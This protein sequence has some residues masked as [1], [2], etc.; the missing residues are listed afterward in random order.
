MPSHLFTCKKR[1]IS[2]YYIPVDVRSQISPGADHISLS[3][4]RHRWYSPSWGLSYHQGVRVC[5]TRRHFYRC[6]TQRWAACQ[7]C[8]GDVSARKSSY[9]QSFGEIISGMGIQS[10]LIFICGNDSIK[11]LN[12]IAAHYKKNI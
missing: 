1:S 3:R 4:P 6:G 11:L 10:K 12:R 5:P 8:G 2:K 7:S 9:R